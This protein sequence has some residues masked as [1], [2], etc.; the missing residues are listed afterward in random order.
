MAFAMQF[1]DPSQQC[2]MVAQ[3]R[4]ARY[5][6]AQFM[7]CAHAAGPMTFNE[8]RFALSLNGDHDALQHQSRDRLAVNSRR[9]RRCP[10]S[11]DVCSQLLD[12][13]PFVRC[14]RERLCRQKPLVLGFQVDLLSQ[15]RLPALL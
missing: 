13:R 8:D 6:S 15:R 5:G 14:Q 11:W 12:C 7:A 9:A 4:Q 2:H 1:A 3:L 10:Q